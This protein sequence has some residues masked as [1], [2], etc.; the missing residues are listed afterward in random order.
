MAKIASALGKI[1]QRLLVVV[2]TPRHDAMR[3]ISA[4]K[5]NQREVR[6]YEDST[7]DD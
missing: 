1:E 4:R 5:A 3:I 7:R 2:Y 6:H